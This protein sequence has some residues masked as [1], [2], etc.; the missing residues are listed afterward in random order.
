MR[1]SAHRN[2]RPASSCGLRDDARTQKSIVSCL[3]RRGRGQKCDK[4]SLSL[5]GRV[6]TRC[7]RQMYLCSCRCLLCPN[8]PQQFWIPSL[9]NIGV[10]LQ[11][12]HERSLAQASPL[13]LDKGKL[14]VVL[15]G[16]ACLVAHLEDRLWHVHGLELRIV[17][18]PLE[19]RYREPRAFSFPWTEHAMRR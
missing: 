9:S 15:P 14:D 4:V 17:A 11:S 10:A 3:R 16:L 12:I 6:R 8:L 19:K 7:H 1:A 18:H 2:L 5:F 13:A